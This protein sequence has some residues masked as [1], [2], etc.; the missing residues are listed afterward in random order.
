[1]KAVYIASVISLFLPSALMPQTSPQALATSGRID[2]A[3]TPELVP[4]IVAFRML[5]AVIVGPPSD[6]KSNDLSSAASGSTTTALSLT[7]RQRAVLR[8]VQLT[9]ADQQIVLSKASAFCK[10]LNGPAPD[11]TFNSAA[12]SSILETA[13]Q[14]KIDELKAEMTPDGFQRLLSHLQQEKRFIKIVPYPQM[15]TH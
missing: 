5:F 6:G 9:E 14:G 1:M 13:A 4:D 12:Q 7:P 10:L 15:H 11:T 3:V 8:S 2:G